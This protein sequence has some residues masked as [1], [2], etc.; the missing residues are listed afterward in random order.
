[1]EIAAALIATVL[2]TI[3]AIALSRAGGDD[4]QE[5]LNEHEDAPAT[6]DAREEERGHPIETKADRPAGP[7]AE[8]MGVADPGDP[9]TDP[10][11]EREGERIVDDIRR[12]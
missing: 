2:L 7:G 9:S 3:A 12:H 4:H 1:M 10:D 11:S 6:G 8:A 5:D